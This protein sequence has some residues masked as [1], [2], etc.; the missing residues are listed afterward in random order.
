MNLLEVSVWENEKD[1]P[2]P[3]SPACD[4]GSTPEHHR[5]PPD[6]DASRSRAPGSGNRVPG[7]GA[8]VFPMY[9]PDG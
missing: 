7:A 5:P 1:L 2:F 3:R 8:R 4:H 6:P 9:H